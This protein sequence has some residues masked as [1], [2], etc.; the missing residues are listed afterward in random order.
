MICF[1][2]IPDRQK[3][4]KKVDQCNNLQLLVYRDP[5]QRRTLLPTTLERM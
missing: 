1:Y 5:L 3:E 4:A 2:F